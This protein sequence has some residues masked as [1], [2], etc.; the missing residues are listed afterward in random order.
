MM[1]CWTRYF[2]PERYSVRGFVRLSTHSAHLIIDKVPETGEHGTDVS[3]DPR[4]NTRT[5]VEK[6]PEYAHA[7][8]ESVLSVYA[9]GSA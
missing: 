2:N 1:V 9:T 6:Y 8:S 5:L 7:S 3:V 4:P